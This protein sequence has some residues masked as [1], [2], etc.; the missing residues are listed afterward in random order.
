LAQTGG[1]L[2][3]LLSHPLTWAAI[4]AVTGL[5]VAFFY[6]FRPSLVMTATAGGVG[7]I[8]LA[9][10]VPIFVRSDAFARS[11]YRWIEAEEAAQAAKLETLAA[12]FHELKFAQGAA[13]IKLLREKLGSL[14]EVLKRRLDSGELTYGRYL[15]MA[16][17]VYGAA[18]DNL[19]E[20][21]AALRSV[22]TIDAGYIRKRLLELDSG[23]ERTDDHEREYKALQE[24][25]ALLEDQTRRIRRL[26]AQNESAMTVIDQTTAALAATRT[27]KGHATLDA[28][29]AM[30]EL[31]Q[32]ARRAGKYAAVR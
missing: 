17:E 30:A 22:S 28:E 19:H 6:W 12:D 4:A 10:W 2:T 32:L 24:R 1:A 23:R 20:V 15:G 3:K 27:E 11:F 31:E 5:E 26:M 9:L 25:T 18:L 8:C 14:V 16:Q 21:A 29:T 13:Q 7:L